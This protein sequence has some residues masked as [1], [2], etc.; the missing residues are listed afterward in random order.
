MSDIINLHDFAARAREILDPGVLAWLDGGA[1]DEITLRENEASFL[2]RR[3]LP[4]VLVDV[5]TIDTSTAL[6]GARS[7]MPVGIAPTAQ[8]ALFHRDGELATA[9][10]AAAA[11]VPFVLSTMSSLTLEEVAKAGGEL[12]F[13]LYVR[14]PVRPESLIER[15]EAAGYRALVLT[16]D[17]PLLGIRERDVRAGGAPAFH[18]ANLP[19]DHHMDPSLNW[20]D[21]ARLRDAS[22]MPLV[23]KGVMTAED[24][25]RSIDHGA[26]AVWV[27]NHGGRQLD[28]A[29]AAIDVV[30]EVVRAVDG[31]AEVYVDGGVRRGVDVLVALALGARAVFV[32]RPPLWALAVDGEAGVRGC[33]GMLEAEL[34]NA[35]TLA[36]ARSVAEVT[37]EMVL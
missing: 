27:S 24:A 22:R 8:H 37:R 19:P 35:M 9:R 13:Q 5:S 4:R 11:G 34:R 1:L 14:Q 10:A 33:L 26:Q 32:G 36:G 6:L 20:D 31:R 15:A 7:A 23:I 18:H 3:V 16:V 25:R 21:L 2:R 29:P 12:W 17:A 30:E 28:R